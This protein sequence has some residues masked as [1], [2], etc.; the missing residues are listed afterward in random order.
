MKVE[1]LLKDINGLLK[2][3]EN[4]L[5]NNP[6]LFFAIEDRLL[7]AIDDEDQPEGDENYKDPEDYYNQD[8]DQAGSDFLDDP[9]A[10]DAESED[11]DA[12][13]TSADDDGETE[14]DKWLREND[15]SYAEREQ[16]PAASAD[17]SPSEDEQAPLDLPQSKAKQPVKSEEPKQRSGKMQDWKARDQYAPQHKAAI[18]KHIAAGYSPREAERLAGAHQAPTD[19]YSALRSG[20]RPS[21]PSPKMLA[22]M[23]GHAHEWLRNA[24][25]KAGEHAEADINPQKYASGKALAA[26]DAAHKDFSSDYDKFLGSDEVKGLAG[27]QRHK[28]IQDWKSKW[29]AENPQHKEK[30]IQAASS[31]KS[32]E[33]A[34]DVR[35]QRLTEGKAAILTAG[36]SSGE[37]NP[38][39]GEYS[40]GSAGESVGH[41]AAAQ[42]VGSEQE[43]EGGG[44]QTN[45][46]KDPHMVFAE[47]N[48]EYVKSLRT[49]L[50][51]KMQPD[52]SERMGAID[53][54]K[55]KGKI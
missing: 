29:K 54:F 14:S 32:L 35:K 38:M 30:A 12:Q 55:N 19:F 31:G 27:R 24:E 21:E 39:A 6:E 1:K 44:Y 36:H 8:E 4:F 48:P 11:E 47:Q 52:Q 25:R 34:Y 40:S 42:N 3:H 41:Q 2:K 15:P 9:E 45:I 17:E 20:V 16:E 37:E 28:A 5:N 51:A 13:Y 43:S 18:D 22:Q 7:K 26:H 53:S 49:K 33:D 23:K 50:A 10:D 46:K